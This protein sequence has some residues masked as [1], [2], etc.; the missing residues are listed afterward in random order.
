MRSNGTEITVVVFA[1]APEPGHTKTRLI[2]ALGA[3]GA[4]LLQ[5]QLTWRALET[6]VA[7]GVGPVELWCAPHASYPFFEECA[8]SFPLRLRGQGPGSLGEKMLRACREVLTRAPGVI[9][10]GT[11][12]PALSPQHLSA[13]AD[14]LA[15]NEA[16]FTPAEDGG[17]VLIGLR[18]AAPAVFE[19]ISWGSAEVVE[20]TRHRLTGLGWRW[21]EMPP[22]WDLD[23][24]RDLERLAA[25]PGLAHLLPQGQ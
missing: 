21:E 8:R 3:E 23:R 15:G 5:A 22:L 7:S 4:A 24:P 25:E 11:D 12:C 9:L 1:R 13:A 20:Q 18:R 10:I 6:A 16:V 2:P 19:D 17:Y 14:A